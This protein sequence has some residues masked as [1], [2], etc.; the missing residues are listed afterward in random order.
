VQLALLLAAA[1]SAEALLTESI[2]YHDPGGRFAEGRFEISLSES[3]PDGTERRTQILLDNGAGVFSMTRAGAG[4]RRVELVVRGDRVEATLDGSASFTDEEA[5]RFR[6]RPDEAR[7]TRNYY[8]FLYGLPM[9]LRDP[10]ARLDPEV[11]E[12][13]FQG[14]AAHELRVT[15]EEEVESDTWYFYLDPDTAALIG[16]RFYH[17]ESANDGEYIVLS[18][19]AEGGGLRLPRT[20]AWYRHQDDGY[21]GTDTIETIE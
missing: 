18:G 2:A 20:R 21:L 1:L 13:E 16:Y 17:D 7:R 15:Y 10:G 11:K 9:K 5:E 6:L 4:G 8:L 3:R 12:T 14:R 19:E